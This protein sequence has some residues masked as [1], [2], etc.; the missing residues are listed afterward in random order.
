MIEVRIL[1]KGRRS[2]ECGHLLNHG[3]DGSRVPHAVHQ[4]HCMEQKY[5][6]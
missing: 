5:D 6:Q 2:L 1:K 4:L 3:M